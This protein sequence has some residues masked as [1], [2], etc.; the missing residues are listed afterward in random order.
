MAQALVLTLGRKKIILA[1]TSKGMEALQ[2][3]MWAYFGTIPEQND[4]LHILS[5]FSRFEGYL[6]VS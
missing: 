5:A 2:V 1:V 4:G 3:K 6:L